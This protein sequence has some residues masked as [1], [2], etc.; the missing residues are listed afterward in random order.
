MRVVICLFV[1]QRCKLSIACV[2]LHLSSLQAPTS[3]HFQFY[4]KPAEGA[5]GAA[6]AAGTAGGLK[7]IDLPAVDRLPESGEL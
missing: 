5:A 4:A 7:V 3:L 6:G 1:S 2:F